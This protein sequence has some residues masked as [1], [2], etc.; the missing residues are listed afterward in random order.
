MAEVE[1]QGDIDGPAWFFFVIVKNILAA[2]G[3]GGFIPLR[4]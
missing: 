2:H 4:L 3:P 1:I